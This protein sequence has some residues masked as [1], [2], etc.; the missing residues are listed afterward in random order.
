MEISSEDRPPPLTIVFLLTQ[1]T[2]ALSTHI[3]LNGSKKFAAR[4]AFVSTAEQ[5]G[6]SA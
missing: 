5:N 3:G 4:F 2:S 6:E 1:R